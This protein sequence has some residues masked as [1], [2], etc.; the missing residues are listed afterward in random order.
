M[1]KL[2]LAATAAALA[3]GYSG[4]AS[5]TAFYVIDD[6]LSAPPNPFNANLPNQGQQSTDGPDS[7]LI[8]G[9]GFTRSV[10]FQNVADASPAYGA[11]I[12][13][14]NGDLKIVNGPTVRSRTT[15]TYTVDSLKAVTTADSYSTVGVVFSNGTASLNG[16]T[17][18]EGFIKNSLTGNVNQSLGTITLKSYID[19]TSNVANEYWGGLTLL[20][21]QLTGTGDILTFIINGPADYDLTLDQIDFAVPEPA[22][23]GLFGMGAVALGIARRRKR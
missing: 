19:A 15:L 20:G 10:L 22:M 12:S 13:I 5:A 1:N 23:I 14:Q 16:P 18:I 8:N 9:L 3:L 2:R 6:F 4:S 17:T 11:S 7:Y 21:S